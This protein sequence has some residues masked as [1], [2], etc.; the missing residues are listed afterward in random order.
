MNIK[1]AAACNK[2]FE[3]KKPV[4]QQRNLGG[5]PSHNQTMQQNQHMGDELI[6]G[7]QSITHT[8]E[9]TQT[10]INE[11]V[12][13]KKRSALGH[14]YSA[15]VQ[16]IQTVNPGHSGKQNSSM[17]RSQTNRGATKLAS[18]RFKLNASQQSINGNSVK[19]YMSNLHLTK[20]QQQ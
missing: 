13:V 8:M 19:R 2:S 6:N 10:L 18:E 11:S 15:A 7:S 16:A 14:R 5:M 20:Q 4:S 17:D 9:S 3:Q 1:Q 12:E